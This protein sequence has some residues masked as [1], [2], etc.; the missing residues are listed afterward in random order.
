MATPVEKLFADLKEDNR[1]S[2]ADL[3]ELSLEVD[4]QADSIFD[5]LSAAIKQEVAPIKSDIV[6]LQNQFD[7][8]QAK[9]DELQA[10]IDSGHWGSSAGSDG[11]PPSHRTRINYD[12]AFVAGSQAPILASAASTRASTFV[13]T[14]PNTV[15]VKGY[16]DFLARGTIINHLKNNCCAGKVPKD[17][18]AA[19]CES[20]CLRFFFF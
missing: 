19:D 2:R 4:R 13:S 5:R 20:M 17:A 9:H 6:S 15:V 3:K 8:L 10:L 14:S 7:L 16:P 11:G 12:G 1:Q 18:V